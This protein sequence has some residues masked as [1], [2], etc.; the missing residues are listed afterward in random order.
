MTKPIDSRAEEAVR[1][2]KVTPRIRVLVVDDVEIVRRAVCEVLR[3]HSD[4]EIVCEA[5]NGTDAV[6]KA[7]EHK[8]DVV[9][10]DIRMPGLDGFACA[11]L[12]RQYLPLIKI[13]IMSQ[14]D[15]STASK[16]AFAAGASGFV[17][18][19]SAAFDLVPEL[20]RIHSAQIG[21]LV[22][23]PLNYLAATTGKG[24]SGAF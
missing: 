4:I 13:V 6:E 22:Y 11:R 24:N 7:R 17:G 19:S 9:L 20:R 16:E 21:G 12:L 10:L 5:S 15:S 18:K 2:G 14:F 23:G 3:A 1:L 8:P